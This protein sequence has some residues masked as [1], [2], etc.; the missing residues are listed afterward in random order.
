M[1]G[2]E[3]A[4][5]MKRRIEK[6]EMVKERKKLITLYADS[7]LNLKL[8]KDD[9]VMKQQFCNLWSKLTSNII[10]LLIIII[11]LLMPFF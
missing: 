3:K 6:E 4:G 8:D 7:L 11:V 5:M 1:R 2:R 9:V 10:L